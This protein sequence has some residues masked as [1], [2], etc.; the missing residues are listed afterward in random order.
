MI[1]KMKKI[2]IAVMSD[3]K[4]DALNRLQDIGVVHVNKTAETTAETADQVAGELKEIHRAVGLLESVAPG[5]NAGKQKSKSSDDWKAAKRA[6]LQLADNRDRLLAQD[7]LLMRQIENQ[8]IWGDFNPERIRNLAAHEVYIKLY[9]CPPAMIPEIPEDCV[10]HEVYRD[11]RQVA[12][13]VIGKMPFALP[14]DEV[15][16]PEKSLSELERQRAEIAESLTRIEDEIKPLA[17]YTPLLNTAKKTLED[18][19]ARAQVHDRLADLGTISYLQGFCPIDRVPA[20]EAA[21]KSEGWGLIIEKPAPDDPVPTL[22]RNPAWAR[23]IEAA[24]KFIDTLPGYFEIDVSPVFLVFLSLF[25]AI[26]IGDAG[27]G[28]I[29]LLIVICVHVWKGRELPKE[30]LY[31]LYICNIMTIL[32]GVATGTYFGINLPAAAFLNKIAFIDSSNMFLMMKICFFIAAVHLTIAHGINTIRYLNSW[33]AAAEFGRI[34]MAWGA[35]FLAKTLILGEPFPHFMIWAGG[36]GIIFALVFSGVLKDFGDLFQFVF[37]IINFFGDTVSYLRLFAVSYA[38]VVL[39]QAF[40]TLATGMSF[41]IFIKGP[42][43][44]LVLFIG[45][46]LNLVL[47]PIAVLVHGLRL[48]LLEFSGH[49]GQEWSGVRYVPLQR[50]AT[51]TQG[52]PGGY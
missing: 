39:A 28:S 52:K 38:T 4:D 1:V 7:D 21:A 6:I 31:L 2:T 9:R 35:Y 48:N 3:L 37:S 8:K 27:Y 10:I 5:R 40:N 30:P 19:L 45:H 47:C 13:A 50:S 11:R 22:L 18:D 25:Y 46:G 34:L 26:L 43:M 15:R 12:F 24:Y 33:M 41:D 44:I 51:P 49:L 32:Y 29:Y 36:G 20:L 23:P 17:A 14:I 16:L 42:L